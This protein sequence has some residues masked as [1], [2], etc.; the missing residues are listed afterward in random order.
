[1]DEELMT[2]LEELKSVY[3]H[4]NPSMTYLG[5]FKI[6]AKDA[7]KKSKPKSVPKIPDIRASAAPEILNTKA[8][9]TQ[10][11]LDIKRNSEA[12][13]SAPTVM[14][15][16]SIEVKAEADNQKQEKINDPGL[17]SDKVK[18]I[19]PVSEPESGQTD[20]VSDPNSEKKNRTPLSDPKPK[21]SIRTFKTH[22]N[23]RVATPAM[24]RYI[25][26]RDK[27]CTYTHN[28]TRCN[29]KA[30]LEV[31][32]IVSYASGGKTELENLTLLCRAH[33]QH[34]SRYETVGELRF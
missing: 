7:L 15:L 16:E 13:P 9:L 22:S 17:D 25:I 3:S 27:T 5:L 2:Q 1:M 18:K 14:R 24:R 23:S 28:G 4:R 20:P 21:K 33:N 6:L 12:Q 11:I 10:E 32:H 31:D 26:D 29:S 19:D 8:N 34:K 30:F